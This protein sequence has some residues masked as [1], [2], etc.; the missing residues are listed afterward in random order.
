MNAR[1]WAGMW[2][3][4]VLN[5]FACPRVGPFGRFQ[6]PLLDRFW[7]VLTRSQEIRPG[8]RFGRGSG[9]RSEALSPL[10]L[11]PLQI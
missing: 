10:E 2:L 11:P 9:S 1:K 5:V 6:G 8:E 7:S 4:I 3:E